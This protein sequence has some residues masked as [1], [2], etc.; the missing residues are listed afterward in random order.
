MG[1]LYARNACTNARAKERKEEPRVIV[2]RRK[3]KK[4]TN[5]GCFL[6]SESF[7]NIFLRNTHV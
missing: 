1:Q 3:K 5:G 4:E 7:T 2:T 6:H